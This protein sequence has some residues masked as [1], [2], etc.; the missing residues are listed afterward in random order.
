[1]VIAE[2]RHEVKQNTRRP[3]ILAGMS[4]HESRIEARLLAALFAVMFA[5]GKAPAQPLSKNAAGT[6]VGS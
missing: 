2:L 4:A 5:I 1:V 6:A 3:A